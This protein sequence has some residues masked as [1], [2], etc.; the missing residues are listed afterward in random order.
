MHPLDSFTVSF[1]H[2]CLATLVSETLVSN[3][4]SGSYV[5]STHGLLSEVV[6]FFLS[7]VSDAE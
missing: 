6:D 7:V 5:H 4:A 3:L 1:I 2:T